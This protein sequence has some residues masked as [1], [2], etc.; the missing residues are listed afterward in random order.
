MLKKIKIQGFQKHRNK[1]IE[2]ENITV[3]VGPSDKGKSSILRGLKWIC[4]NR[5]KGDTFISWDRENAKVTLGIDDHIVIRRKGKKGN[6]YYLD[7]VKYAAFGNG[8][9]Q[10]IANILNVGPLNWQSQ[11][12]S[13]YLFSK[14]PGEVAKELNK[15]VALDT[16]DRV[17]GGLASEL[18]KAK[19]TTA[20]VRDRLDSARK[21]R[22]RLSWIKGAN[23]ELRGIEALQEQ[24]GKVKQELA[25][26][27]DLLGEGLRAK[28]SI[29][30]TGKSIL[31]ASRAIQ[32][33]ERDMEAVQK[34]K[35]GY[36]SLSRVIAEYNAVQEE[37]SESRELFGESKRELKWQTRGRMCPV[38]GGKFNGEKFH[39]V[40]EGNCRDKQTS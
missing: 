38:C 37:L 36:R 22:K 26:I 32:E 40:R 10:D 28:E 5:P 21:E 11:H 23:R 31:D 35:E 17:L 27:E 20:V 30:V 29:E 34:V 1:G 12:S 6:H 8:V 25:G 7:G 2:F 3:I 18:R 13:H 24:F 14:T 39:D 4:T 15:I 9:P 16:I 19:A 33:I